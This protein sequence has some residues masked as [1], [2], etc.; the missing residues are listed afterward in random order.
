MVSGQCVEQMLHE[1]R[2]YEEA[3]NIVCAF[4]KLF[5]GSNTQIP[6][7][8]THF[9]RFPHIASEG[10]DDS[11]TPDFT[12]VFNDGAGLVAEIAHVSDAH[13][14]SPE[15]LCNQ[16]ANYDLLTELPIGNG[17]VEVQ[18]VDVLVLVPQYQ[19]LIAAREVIDERLLDGSHPYKP[20]VKPL[21]ASYVFDSERF[22]F[23]RILHAD[24]GILREAGRPEKDGRPSGVGSW[25]GH[26]GIN[27]RPEHFVDVKATSAFI[28]DPPNDLYLA[29]HLWMRVFPVL[30]DELGGTVTVDADPAELAERLRRE[31]GGGVHAKD[32]RRALDLLTKARLA[33][34]T[35]PN[36]WTVAFRSLQAREGVKDTAALLAQRVCDP[37][38][39]SALESPALRAAPKPAVE[40]LTMAPP[41]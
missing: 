3:V 6:Q 5:T 8:V 23:E 39:S 38:T 1:Y 24:N 16:I 17:L 11:L 4:E 20:S 26:N 27:F 18:F 28:N 33:D 25:L 10:T 30:A 22:H 9:S 15:K 41:P 29:T 19:A 32:V 2:V 34:L 12:V 21:V 35:A 14:G 36:H 37:P 13:A 7:T 31:N 40:Q